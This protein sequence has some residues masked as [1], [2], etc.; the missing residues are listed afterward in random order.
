MLRAAVYCRVSTEDQ[1]NGVSL[2]MQRQRCVEYVHSRGW[3][4]A[5]TYEDIET[6][7]IDV[8]VQLAVLRR[9]LSRYDA[10]VFWKLDRLVR[11]V[12]VLCQLIAECEQSGVTFTSATEPIDTLEPMGRTMVYV[13]GAMAELESA[14]TSQRVRAANRRLLEQGKSPWHPRYGYRRGPDGTIIV[15]DAEAAVIRTIFERRAAGDTYPA[16]AQSLDG[17]D[18]MW[19]SAQVRH[20]VGART[21]I[22]ELTVGQNVK[23][24][25]RWQNAPRSEWETV[26][27]I[28][29]AIISPDLWRG[30]HPGRMRGRRPTKPSLFRGILRCGVCRHTLHWFSDWRR[31]IC[32]GRRR[33][34]RCMVSQI[35]EARI[36]ALFEDALQRLSEPGAHAEA[37][38]RDEQHDEEWLEVAQQKCA[39]AWTAYVEDGVDL[40][41]VRAAQRNMM[42]AEAATNAGLRPPMTGKPLEDAVTICRRAFEGSDLAAGNRALRRTLAR[43]VVRQDPDAIQLVFWAE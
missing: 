16:I 9:R 2:D 5:D 32:D 24:N 15:H 17:D 19:T 36:L 25:G 18:R 22:G 20:T 38:P 41:V 30:A 14:N 34:K 28:I 21:Y 8:R 1:R 43:I 33:F 35:S 23:K 40:S 6:G 4:V 37:E 26:E 10:L 42:E 7:T 3:K 13:A 31:F 39:R 11:S 29:P 27:D 12:P